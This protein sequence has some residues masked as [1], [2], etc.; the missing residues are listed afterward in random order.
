MLCVNAL[1]TWCLHLWWT[2]ASHVCWEAADGHESGGLAWIAWL[3]GSNAKI[4]SKEENEIGRARESRDESKSKSKSHWSENKSEG[5]LGKRGPLG[6][7]E[8]MRGEESLEENQVK[9]MKESGCGPVCRAELRIGI[10]LVHPPG[11][12]SGGHTGGR[13][14]WGVVSHC[15]PKQGTGCKG[16]GG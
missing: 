2:H 8:N 3:D 9:G 4:V 10:H 11:G 6:Q 15:Q 5:S 16:Q 13:R 7:H 1:V 12:H 14:L